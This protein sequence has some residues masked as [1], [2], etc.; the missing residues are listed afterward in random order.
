MRKRTS[1]DSFVIEFDEVDFGNGFMGCATVEFDATLED[2]GIGAYEFWGTPGNHVDM[3]WEIQDWSI[4]RF[5][6]W[7]D[8][9]NEIKWVYGDALDEDTPMFEFHKNAETH[10]EGCEDE[11][12][13]HARDNGDTE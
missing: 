7:D 12:T 4:V 3:Q 1:S 13:D 8:D 5:E 2:N 11:M 9:G 6:G 10:I